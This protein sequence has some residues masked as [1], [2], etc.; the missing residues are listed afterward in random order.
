MGLAAI[1]IE[2]LEESARRA[3]QTQWEQFA[4]LRLDVSDLEVCR[5]E[6]PEKPVETC[7]VVAAD[8]G[9]ASVALSPFHL[10]L[11]HV[12][13]DRGRVHLSEFFPLA[14][15]ADD[16]AAVFERNRILREFAGHLLLDWR[17]LTDL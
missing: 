15:L 12:T 10:E 5:I 6:K 17:D 13:D 2:Q 8:A 11:L 16:L 1:P 9:L 3:A 7:G 14:T 4:R